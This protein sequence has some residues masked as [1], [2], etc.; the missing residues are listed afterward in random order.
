MHEFDRF[1][2]AWIGAALSPR[3]N[4]FLVLSSGFDDATALRDIVADWLFDID[5]FS[6]LHCP[7]RRQRVPVIWCRNTGN[8][9]RLVFETLPHVEI[10]GRTGTES[11]FDLISS[12]ISDNFIRVNDGGDDT[13]LTASK[14]VDM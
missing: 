3:L 1:A 2:H 5:I 13:I 7:D 4:D 9:N 10:N 12:A 14:S 11:L 6:S 8:V